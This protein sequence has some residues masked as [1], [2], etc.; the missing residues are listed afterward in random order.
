L[1][2][3]I[4]AIAVDATHL[5]LLEAIPALAGQR[6]VV[7]IIAPMDEQT[8]LLHELRQA[9]SVQSEAER[10]TEIALAEEGLQGSHSITAE[11]PGEAEG[12]WWE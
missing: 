2:T 6:V 1:T 4:E 11:F 3:E 9:Y 8:R 12:L 5:E 10:Q 7:K